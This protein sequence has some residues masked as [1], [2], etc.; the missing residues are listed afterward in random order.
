MVKPRSALFLSL[1]FGARLLA[2]QDLRVDQI[3]SE[4]TKKEAELTPPEDPRLQKWILKTEDSAPYRLLKSPEGFGL[5]FGN[6]VP[7]GGF[8]IGPRYRKILLDGHL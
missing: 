5:V 8:A 1:C 3:E 2:Q 7:G 4:R 6:L